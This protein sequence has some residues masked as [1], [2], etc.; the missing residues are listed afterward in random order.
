M[1]SVVAVGRSLVA[2]LLAL[3]V[4]IAATGW[5]YIFYPKVSLPGPLINDA[6]PLDELSKHS[7]VPLLLFVGI[8]TVASLLLGSLARFARAERSTAAA[9]LALAVGLWTY[10]SNGFSL[11]IVRQISAHAALHQAS[12]LRAT[13]IPV[14]LAGLGGALLGRPRASARSRAPFLLAW[15]VAGAG[16]IGVVNALL[17]AHG[18]SLLA[19][20]AMRPFAKALTGPIGVAL[21][22]AAFGLGRGRR[23]A[24]QLALALL[25]LSTAIHLLHRFG[26]GAAIT[27]ALTLGL[28]AGRHRFDRPGDPRARPRVL[29]RL[30]VAAAVVTGYGL[31]AIWLNRL[32]AD[33]FY[34]LGFALDETGRALVGLNLHGSAHLTGPFGNWFPDSVFVLGL[35]S[36]AAVLIPWLAPWRYRLAPEARER[37]LA[38]TLVAS[39]GGDTLAPFVLRAD[40]SYFF[41]EDERAL[42]AYR[43]VGGVAIVSGDPI[44]PRDASPELIDAFIAFAHARDWRI[45]ILGASEGYLDLYR[46]R[47]LHALYHGDEAVVDV[48]SFSLEGRAMRKVRQSVHRLERLGYTAEVLRP[49]EIDGALRAELQAILTT[50]LGQEPERGFVMTLDNLFRVDDA[51]FV[52]G[53]GADGAPHGFL[54]FA[55][56]PVC[57]ALSLSSM[58][59]LRDTPNGFNE[60]LIS[61]TVGWARAQDF[62]RV[63]LNFAPFAALL[64]P[65]AELNTMQRAQRQA[66]LAV[67][68]HFQLDN[69]LLFNR[70]FLPEYERR[71]VVYERRLDLPRVGIAA[72]AAEAYLPFTGRKIA[73]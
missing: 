33:Q 34:T 12:Q 24:W 36:A 14:M 18:H 26:V 64:A 16:L 61:V 72:L 63:S 69:L 44:G 7:T 43:V 58:P 71:F 11:L 42:L 17:P 35:A 39:F 56:S 53:R 8:W 15:C 45:A 60:W 57:R 23:R 25:G 22:Y 13:W 51:V 27:G 3:A 28:V 73:V 38:R 21:I 67:K 10:F 52:I 68:G 47:G 19:T 49:S 5:L 54:H 59:R 40:K 9:L 46:S 65:E 20:L 29:G 4:L 6:L 62:R 37:E 31:A 50:W 32:M 30:L 55:V 70:K 41:A 2:G 48:E 1:R 66:L